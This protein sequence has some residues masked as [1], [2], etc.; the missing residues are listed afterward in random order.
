MQIK[1]QTQTLVFKII[2]EVGMLCF[3]HCQ[4]IVRYRKDQN[5]RQSNLSLQRTELV[6]H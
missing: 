2:I 3:S 5:V 4:G 1:Q 6:L